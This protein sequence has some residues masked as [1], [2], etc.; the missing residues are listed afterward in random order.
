MLMPLGTV[1]ADND[2][3]DDIDNGSADTNE[4]GDA[5]AEEEE[6]EE[7]EEV[8]ASSDIIDL[9]VETTVD[10][11]VANMSRIS[12]QG[13]YTIY[14]GIV[15]EK[16]N[17]QNLIEGAVYY[18]AE[19][20]TKESFANFTEKLEK[21]TAVEKNITSTQRELDEA[22][23]AL[24]RAT[25]ALVLVDTV[26]TPIEEPETVDKTN[27]QS[28]IDGISPDFIQADYTEYT[29][30]IYTN[31]IESAKEINVKADAKQSEV[32]AAIAELSYTTGKLVNAPEEVI[33]VVSAEQKGPMLVATISKAEVQ[34]G[35]AVNISKNGTWVV[36]TD[37]NY[38]K[39]N[40]FYIRLLSHEIENAYV[41]T[42][43]NEVYFMDV[44]TGEVSDTFKYESSDNINGRLYKNTDGK[45]LFTTLE[46]ERLLAVCEE[47][48]QNDKFTLYADTQSSKVAMFDKAANKFWWSTPVN[49]YGDSTVIDEAKQTGM[50]LPQRNQA[51]SGLILQYGDLKQEKRNETYVYSKVAAETG[52]VTETWKLS[53]KG[54]TISYKFT[55]FL[56]IELMFL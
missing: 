9:A 17:L 50:K 40:K 18:T 19:S 16:K 41:T 38:S 7:E 34:N 11:V 46:T 44:T 14:K 28:A 4:N 52:K 49:P 42:A 12:G 23:I 5:A 2:N 53:D 21:A 3:P 36:E 43:L 10:Y 48:T 54:I 29:W 32:D 26:E 25:T 31:A 6:E 8:D 13:K 37:S 51:A 1:F 33:A 24:D 20:Y 55:L 27:L 39:V 56:M 15:K 47:V 45:M 30:E 22:T 35:S